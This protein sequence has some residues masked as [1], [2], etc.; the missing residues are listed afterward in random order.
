MTI[1]QEAGVLMSAPIWYPSKIGRNKMNIR[2]TTTGLFFSEGR[3][4]LR[5][6]C[7]AVYCLPVWLLAVLT[8]VVQTGCVSFTAFF[9]PK[10]AGTPIIRDVPRE[11]AKSSLPFYFLEPP[12]IINVE[13]IHLAPKAPYQ[14]RIFDVLQVD[15]LGAPAE[16]P[17]N[18][19]FSVEPGGEI[20]LGSVYGGVK[21]DGLTLDEAQEAI[22]RHLT[23]SDQNPNGRLLNPQVS[24]K[25]ARMTD[26]QQIAGN[27][28]IGPDGFITLGS[29]GRVYV[30]GLTVD[31][32]RDAIEFHLSKHLEH[33]QV[34]V[35]I[36][37]YNSK[38]YY[39]I[40]QSAATGEQVLKFPFTG[41]EHVL[42]AIANSNGLAPNSSKRIW[43]ARPVGNSNKPMVLPV[44][45]VDVTAYAKPDTNYQILPGDRVFIVEDRFVALDGTLARIIAPMERI[46]GFSLLGANTATRLSGKVLTGGGNQS[47]Y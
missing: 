39:V 44:D 10:P 30:N 28:M 40:F 32:C 38:A 25:L 34:A 6:Q 9:D 13:A 37:S 7:G 11:T 1:W 15:V 18:G 3:T 35:D 23:Y 2:Q 31:E 45:W 5:L 19:L 41:N 46:M 43:V 27:H 16:D 36:F 29:Y 47:G 22:R 4:V 33:P 24:V 20:K 14:L 21:I 42:D 26:M 12:D 8:I 17:I